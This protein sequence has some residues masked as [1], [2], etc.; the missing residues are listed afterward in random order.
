MEPRLLINSCSSLIIKSFTFQA[1]H[2]VEEEDRLKLKSKHLALSY[3]FKS[4]M[5]YYHTYLRSANE[6]CTCIGLFVIWKH[7]LKDSFEWWTVGF[8]VIRKR[9]KKPSKEKNPGMCNW[10]LFL[11]RIGP[12]CQP[13]KHLYV[14]WCQIQ[15]GYLACSIIFLCDIFQYNSVS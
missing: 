9:Q 13:L 10:Y 14:N 7:E 3:W 11:I 12:I 4:I 8:L 2:D 5:I 6:T 1:V 15:I